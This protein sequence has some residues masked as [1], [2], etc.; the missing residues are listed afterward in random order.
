T[1]SVT[2]TDDNS[3]TK[4]TSFVTV[5][6]PLAI[7]A[8]A[9]VSSNYNG[10]EISCVGGTD[11]E[12]TISAFGGTGAL[13]Y[14]LVE[15]PANVTGAATGVF[16]VLP[17]GS[18]TVTVTDINGCFV[19]TAAVSVD[20]PP[21][22]SGSTAIISNYSGAHISCFGLSDGSVRT[23]ATGGTGLL[24]Y[25]LIE[26]PG[27]TTG[28]VNGIYTG[29]PSGSYT[30]RVTDA[31]GCTAV[32]AGVTLVD[33]PA[34]T[35]TIN[36]TSN[37]NG[38]DVSCPGDNDGQ[39]TVV[40]SDGTGTLGYTLDQDG[41]NTSGDVSGVYDNLLAGVWS[42]TITDQ[43]LCAVTTSTVT[44]SN[45][46]PITG[47]A[48]VTS[49]YNGSEVTC[50]GATDG[51]V[52]AVASGGTGT[53]GYT[54][55]QDAGNVTGAVTG[56]FTG[57]GAG[58][59]TITVTDQNSCTFT[60]VA[61][62]VDDP[63][64]ITA[65]TAISSDFNGE[66]LSCF[67]T[68]DG[69]ITVT[70]GGGTGAYTYV[71]VE[72]PTNITGKFSGVFAGLTSGSY[73]VSVTD[74]NGCNVVSAAVVLVDPVQLTATGAVTSSYN[75]SDVTCFGD[76]D[77]EITITA[78]GGTAG[79]LL[80]ELIQIPANVTGAV[81]GIFTGLPAAA[82]TVRVT[83]VNGC[84]VTTNPT[85]VLN[86]ALL[87]ATAAVTSDYFGSELSC[88]GASDGQVTVTPAG[89]TGGYTFALIEIPLN[90]SG[91][92]TGIYDGLPSGSYTVT[93]RDVNL[94]E[95]TTIAV[96]IDEPAVLTASAAVTS[97]YNGSEVSCFGASD[98]IVTVTATGG[99]GAASY[100]LNPAVNTTGDITGIY[101]GLPSG[102]YDVTVTDQNGCFVVTLPVDVDDPDE[103]IGSAAITSDYNGSD[104]SC[105]G[106]SDG[107]IEATIIGG[108]VSLQY[109]SNGGLSWQASDVF[110]LLPAATYH[111]MVK[112]VNNCQ[113]DL[114]NLDI[115]NPDQ[116]IID[117]VRVT[118]DFNGRD[119]SCA[120]SNDGEA[121]VYPIGGTT[122]LTGNLNYEWFTDPAYLVSTGQTT[123]TATGLAAGIYYVK[124]WD[125]N[126]CSAFGN[127]TVSAPPALFGI[128][129][130][131]SNHNGAQVSCNGAT[132][133]EI[134]VLSFNGTPSYEYSADGKGTWSKNNTI[135]GLGAGS[136]DVW[137]MDT[138]NCEYNVGTSI[139]IEPAV[140]T[141]TASVTSNYFGQDVT[142]VS[143]TNGIITVIAGGGTGALQ[144]SKDGGTTWQVTPVF[145]GLGAGT[146]DFE[147]KDVNDCGTTVSGILVS[148]PP[149]LTG[150]AA[151]TSNHFG[152]HVSCFGAFDGV[153]TIT[154]TSTGSGT[155]MY[156]N[157]GG[158]TYQ[159]LPAFTNLNA[160]DY[161]MSIRDI[162]M[163]VT[164]L[165]TV[166]IVD[167]PAMAITSVDVTSDHNGRD[168]SC[169]GASDGEATIVHNGGTGTIYYEW[170]YDAGLGLP[171]GQTTV[172]A[173][174]LSVGTYYVKVYDDNNC[175]AYGN[176]TLVDP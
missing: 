173:T 20:D 158:I 59:Y 176:V 78:L 159:A 133:G 4:L 70:A 77:G 154:I 52:R 145:S 25:E 56:E 155:V 14:V 42:V 109:S 90:T 71:L 174:G 48:S 106:A 65:T 39:I 22:I 83:D 84:N 26:I 142:C 86:P 21:A 3:C 117:S 23:T 38:S 67:G 87:S 112:D 12:I 139:I 45:P 80:Y 79:A 68:N 61:V 137:I 134:T 102:T 13:S 105:T 166:T 151:V 110:D 19:T 150:S 116:V 34:I 72:Q 113:L 97:N 41:A 114:G 140:I 98:G 27:N 162:N 157:N 66:H 118:S 111:I 130:V 128:A 143:A 93:V 18:Y 40:G 135:G 74:A 144:Y 96:T 58:S 132:D 123:A 33:P 126:N 161:D 82:Y 94:C 5:D 170:Y 43:N 6:D 50:A 30:V 81:N 2:V 101:T 146:Y 47:T 46:A 104:V 138:N 127:V 10:S 16:T 92:A 53:L 85:S 160:G 119:I 149:A 32:S 168:I 75:G 64:A 1:Y 37:Y 57:L 164:D 169:V 88:N 73:T 172:T 24:S 35:Y 103:I 147:V 141:A 121:T 122:T 115:V 36:V 8:F 69:E 60:T 131:T 95:I 152:A 124:V 29:L 156:S 31:N 9:T 165:G 99:T 108:T 28:D 44:I 51:I 63:P 125:D 129:T 175:L 62:T 91:D 55:D 17:S 100:V 148:D 107:T 54:L 49:N 76:S 171:V 7:S 167:P 89:G 11:G 163:C 120:T 153:I 136:H 15:I